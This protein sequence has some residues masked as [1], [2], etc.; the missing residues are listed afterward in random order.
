VDRLPRERLLGPEH[1]NTLT[2]RANLASSYWS[3]GRT[4]EP[5]DLLERV[6]ADRERLLGP[7]H[8]DTRTI[9]SALAAWRGELQ[10]QSG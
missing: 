8:A 1:P 10:H 2:A 6:L 5:I 9:R 7:E 4:G 3:A